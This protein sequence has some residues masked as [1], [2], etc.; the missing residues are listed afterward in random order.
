MDGKEKMEGRL[1][2]VEALDGRGHH[3][4]QGEV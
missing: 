3:R 1:V 2:A 4:D